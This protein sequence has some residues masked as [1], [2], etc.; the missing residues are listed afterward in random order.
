[1]AK[2]GLIRVP[3]YPQLS[4][5]QSLHPHAPLVMSALLFWMSRNQTQATFCEQRHNYQLALHLGLA[6]PDFVECMQ[7]LHEH[8]LFIKHT[9]T[10]SPKEKT[11]DSKERIEVRLSLDFIAL[12][13]LLESLGSHIK[14]KLLLHAADDS[15]DIYDVID[16]KQLPLVQSLHGH[17]EGEIYHAAA[18]ETCRFL[19]YINEHCENLA[20]TA[21]A[22]GWKLL[23][24]VP[25]DMSE[26]AYANLLVERFMRPQEKAIDFNFSDGNF[27][28]PAFEEIKGE[29][30]STRHYRKHQPSMSLAA[31]LMLHLTC[32]FNEH[33]YFTSELSVEQLYSA[34]MLCYEINHKL[35]S[36]S[37]HYYTAR[38]LSPQQLQIEQQH[39]QDIVRKIT[40]DNIS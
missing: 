5:M 2:Q 27:F 16:D 6:Y 31:A 18:L 33:L 15:F 14:L 40:E 23:L 21:I 10:L 32:H 13:Q 34:F 25:Y 30:H 8:K 38:K 35:P 9:F 11:A 7:K 36:L 3:Y 39:Y 24:T 37:E 20:A 1:M 19:I 12:Q 22:P 4:C 26:E 28:L 17:L 29:I